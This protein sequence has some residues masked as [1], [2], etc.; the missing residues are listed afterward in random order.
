MSLIIHDIHYYIKPI[1]NQKNAWSEVPDTIKDT[2]MK[3]G[4]PQA[5]QK[6]LA[7][8]GAQFESEVIY[9]SLKKEWAA[10]GVLFC[11]MNTGLCDHPII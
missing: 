11:D 5:E 3:L 1:E 10:Q 4:I 2:F 6:M 9:K 7:G 8:V